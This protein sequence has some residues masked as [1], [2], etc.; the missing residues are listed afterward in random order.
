MGLCGA[1]QPACSV[2]IVLGCE[3]DLVS[4]QRAIHTRGRPSSRGS[5][6]VWLGRDGSKTHRGGL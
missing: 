3:M 1:R 2:Q 4:L 6:L 5:S